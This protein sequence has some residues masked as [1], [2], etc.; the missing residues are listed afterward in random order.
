MSEQPSRKS[1]DPCDRTNK[2]LL[3]SNIAGCASAVEL[4]KKGYEILA[5][6]VEGLTEEDAKAVR[7]VL[8]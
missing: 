2:S 5:K 3:A 7:L 4:K 8:F 1:T 6:L